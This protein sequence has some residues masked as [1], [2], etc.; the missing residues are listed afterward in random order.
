MI[1]VWTIFE[2]A[3]MTLSLIVV[4]CGISILWP[5]VMGAP[6]I[7]TSRKTVR[8]ML[9]L[10]K[11]TE[12]D[13]LIDLGSGDGRIIIMAA[14]EFGAKAIGIEADPLRVYWSRRAIRR[15]R[16]H[17]KASVTRGNFFHQSLEDASVVSVYQ[18]QRVNKKMKSKLASELKPGTRVVSHSFTF[19]GWKV[20][21]ET[22]NPDLYLYIV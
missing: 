12:E 16:L 8:K 4:F 15:K 10:A 5:M 7:P 21:E 1:E 13:T 14:E 20:A 2:L 6:W 22:R 19:D 3:L 18:L 17:D 11:V 9:E